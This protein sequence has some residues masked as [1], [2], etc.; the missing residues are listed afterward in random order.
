AVQ[1]A[2]FWGIAHRDW[3]G[4][5]SIGI[6]EVQWQRG[7][8]YLTLVYQIDAGRKRLLWVGQ[9]RTVATLEKFFDL[10]G[11]QAAQLKFVCSDMWSNYLEVVAR[12][13]GAAI[14]VLDR[15]HIVAKMNKAIDEVR[16]GEAKR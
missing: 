5:E 8:R 1:H 16:A 15:F 14:H 3:S 11:E 10:L 9:E 4:I 13:A 12:R 2:V 6:D 7:H